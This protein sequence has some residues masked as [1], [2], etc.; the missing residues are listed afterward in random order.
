[1]PAF[2]NAI[3]DVVALA[4][5]AIV[6]FSDRHTQVLGRES[7][8]LFSILLSLVAGVL[9]FDIPAWLLD[10]VCFAGSRMLCYALDTLYYLCQIAYCYFWLLFSDYWNRG[11]NERLV[12]RRWLFAVP[13]F[14]ETLLILT[15]PL[16]GWIFSIDAMSVYARGPLYLVNLLPYYFYI[17]GSF[18]LS[19]YGCLAAREAE[20]RRRSLSLIVFMF[21]PVCGVVLESLYYGVSWTWPF[22]ALSL[23]MVYF[24]VQQQYLSEQRIEVLRQAEESAQLKSELTNSRVSIMLSQMQPHFLYNALSSIKAL[25][26]RNPQLAAQAAG[27][28]A[29]FLRSNMDSLTDDKPVSFTQ[30]LEHTKHYLALELIRFQDRL[31]VV[32]DIET[33]LFRLPTLTLQPIVENAVRYGT[34]PRIEGGTVTISTRETADAFVVTVRDDGIGF[35]P[36]DEKHDGRS[37]IGIRNVSERLG[38]MC[39]GTLAVSSAIGTGTEVVISIPKQCILGGPPC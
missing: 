22:S 37:H 29:E 4:I 24:S 8:R 17:V 1:M 21:L 36:L 23:L 28:F 33:D 7:H 31:H 2:A 27:D 10:G 9:L 12:R 39:G 30:E 14:F 6:M 26:T 35:D 5:V 15:N 38:A 13:L 11:D 20:R 19:V 25:C 34:M 16:T 3:I 32:Y 18:A